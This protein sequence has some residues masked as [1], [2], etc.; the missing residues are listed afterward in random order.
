MSAGLDYPSVG[1]EHA[2]LLETGRAEYRP[3]DDD[4]AM[5]AFSLL[6]R[7]CLLYTSRCV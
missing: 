5:E 4:A 7:T 1:P 2:Y 6:C 3:V